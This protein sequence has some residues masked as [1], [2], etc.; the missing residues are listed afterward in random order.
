MRQMRQSLDNFVCFQI[1]NQRYGFKSKCFFSTST[2]KALIIRNQKSI[3]NA[4][5]QKFTNIGTPF[6]KIEKKIELFMNYESGL[7]TKRA[8]NI[9]L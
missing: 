7:Y 5:I 8:N 1:K 6:L 4:Q 9:N 2:N 3:Y